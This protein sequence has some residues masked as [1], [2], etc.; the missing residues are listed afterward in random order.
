MREGLGRKMRRRNDRREG[1]ERIEEIKE[2]EG[3]GWDRSEEE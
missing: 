3:R 1:K 2:G